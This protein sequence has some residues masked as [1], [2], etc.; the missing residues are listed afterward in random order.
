MEI[1]KITEASEYLMEFKKEETVN[2][3]SL[4]KKKVN[5]PPRIL[6]YTIPGWGKTTLAASMP[7]P[8]FI[9]IEDGMTGLSVD[10]FEI[11]KT[12]EDI[13]N[14]IRL[15]INEDHDYK[16]VVIDTLSSLERNIYDQVCKDHKKNSV[17]EIG[18]AKGYSFA[19]Y[20][21]EKIVDGLNILRGKGIAPVL[22]AHSE[23]KTIQDPIVD[24]YDKYII[25]LHKHPAAMIMQLCDEIFFGT[26]KT[27]VTKQGEGF[28]KT[29]KGV[30]QGERV[31]LTE[32]RPAFTAKSRNGLTFEIDI[33]KVNGWSNIANNFNKNKSEEK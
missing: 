6:I 1:Y 17:D 8:I 20:Y 28:S 19:L 32:E 31:I 7:K 12:Y 9:D 10:S 18:Y 26:H 29:S 27:I 25:K 23:V 14:Y 11:P 15:L 3:N 4:L 22:L 24:A 16:T 13:E 21:W 30:G 2:L 5:L 33:P